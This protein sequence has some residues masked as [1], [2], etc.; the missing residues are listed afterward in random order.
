MDASF[1]SNDP[2]PRCL[3]INNFLPG[4]EMSRVE[5][6]ALKQTQPAAT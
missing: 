2:V 5:I 4:Q 6:V 3:D 1:L